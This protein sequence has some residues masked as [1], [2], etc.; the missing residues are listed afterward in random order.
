MVGTFLLS[1][2]VV[3]PHSFDSGTGE[4]PVVPHTNQDFHRV[5][6]SEGSLSVPDMTGWEYIGAENN[7]NREL[8]RM[9]LDVPNMKIPF[10]A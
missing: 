8:S 6:D 4:N 2:A 5:F 3:S 9:K 1:D 7:W 10:E